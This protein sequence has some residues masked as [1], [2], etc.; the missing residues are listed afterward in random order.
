MATATISPN[1]SLVLRTPAM[2]EAGRLLLICEIARMRREVAALETQRVRSDDARLAEFWRRCGEIADD[3]DFCGE[4]D[5][6]V[7]ALGGTPRLENEYEIEIPIRIRIDVPVTA[8]GRN[9]EVARDVAEDSLDRDDIIAAI[10]NAYRINW[11][12]DY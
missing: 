3:Y 1:T 11:E 8:T 9:Y 7:E 2:A 6:I 4:Y 12:L 10:E 5:R